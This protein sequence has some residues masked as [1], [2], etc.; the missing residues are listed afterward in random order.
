M[1]E[2]D[3]RAPVATFF[4]AD[5]L[6]SGETATLGEAATHHARVKHLSTGDPVTLTNGCGSLAAGRL[7]TVRRDSV[8]VIVDDVQSVPRLAPI[9]LCVAIGDRDRMLWLAE[10]CTE[11]GI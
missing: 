5:A 4:F 7:G 10:K 11:L 3:G 1:V 8:D 2:H 6:V 9:H